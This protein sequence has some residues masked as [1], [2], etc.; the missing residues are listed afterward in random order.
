MS[1]YIRCEGRVFTD[2]V[3]PALFALVSKD[4]P[5]VSSRMCWNNCMTLEAGINRKKALKF[6][7]IQIFER[8]IDVAFLYIFVFCFGKI[9]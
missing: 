1:T 2:R 7:V 3:Y 5:G 4:I 9:A 8:K 6:H